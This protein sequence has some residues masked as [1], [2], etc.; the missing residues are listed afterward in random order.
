[1]KTCFPNFIYHSLHL[2][3][4]PATSDTLIS[5]KLSIMSTLAQVFCTKCGIKNKTSSIYCFKC[6]TKLQHSADDEEKE[7]DVMNVVNTSHNNTCDNLVIQLNRI[8]YFNGDKDVMIIN[9]PHK[10]PKFLDGERTLSAWYKTNTN[11]VII[12]SIGS[13]HA[14]KPY[15]EQ[16][17]IAAKKDGI[18][19]YGG[20]GSNDFTFSNDTSEKINY[21]DNEWRH[22]VVI[23]K[24]L[25]AQLYINGKYH[26]KTENH[27]YETGKSNSQNIIIGGWNDQNRY[28]NGY[29]GDIRVYD[30][31]LSKTQIAILYNEGAKRQLYDH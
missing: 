16:F 11:D 24:G 21:L 2:C 1:M 12:V 6:G 7:M 30:T 3:R 26:G 5:L 15:N 13:N 20:A 28:Y 31:A 29:I 27:K 17:A 19:L 22:I 8:L 10:F 14:L 18:R 9:L 23:K 25:N 4:Y